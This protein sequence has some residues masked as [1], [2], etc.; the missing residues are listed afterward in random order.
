MNSKTS[1][2]KIRESDDEPVYFVIWDG[3]QSVFFSKKI[4]QNTSKYRYNKIESLANAG[5]FF[6]EELSRPASHTLTSLFYMINVDT[7]RCWGLA[8]E[9]AES[10]GLEDIAF[11]I[12]RPIAFNN[13]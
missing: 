10:V 6:S 7:E 13:S 4:H 9:L 11:T 3:I 12:H 2:V 1:E 5:E 8:E